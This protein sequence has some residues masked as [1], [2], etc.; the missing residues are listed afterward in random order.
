MLC[1]FLVFVLHLTVVLLIF[2]F[3]ATSAFH[4]ISEHVDVLI[5][6]LKLPFLNVYSICIKCVK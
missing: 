4:E 6:K 3:F 5:G 2:S 1:M